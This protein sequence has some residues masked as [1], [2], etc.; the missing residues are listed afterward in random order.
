MAQIFDLETGK[1]PPSA[2]PEPPGVTGMGDNTDVMEEE[3]AV[4]AE[5][6][7]EPVPA[8]IQKAGAE[9]TTPRP[10][11]LP[12]SRPCKSLRVFLLGG[13]SLSYSYTGYEGFVM[14]GAGRLTLL[15]RQGIVAL[16]G[17]HLHPLADLIETHRISYI[18]EQHV[19]PFLAAVEDAYIERIDIGKPTLEL[20]Q[21]V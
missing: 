9:D 14:Q 21:R 1:K 5:M 12:L 6:A 16:V 17:R 19:S 11:G 18:R 2:Q 7:V 8:A 4:I 13:N 10:W 15:F 3:S 20:W